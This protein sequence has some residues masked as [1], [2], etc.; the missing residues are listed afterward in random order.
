MTVKEMYSL[1][2]VAKNRI[3]VRLLTDFCARN[4]APRV[5]ASWFVDNGCLLTG[6]DAEQLSVFKSYITTTLQN[7]FMLGHDYGWEREA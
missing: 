1:L 4:G 2:F 7:L 3:N 5:D 6:K